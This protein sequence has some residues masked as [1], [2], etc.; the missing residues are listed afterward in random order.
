MVGAG[1]FN[2]AIFHP[3]WFVDKGLISEDEVIEDQI[4][5][6]DDSLLVTSAISAFTADW[7]SVRVTETKAVFSTVEQGR[8]P[9]LKDLARGVLDLLPET[10]VNAIGINADAHFRIESEDAWHAIGDQFLPKD[11]WEPI[12]EDGTWVKRAGDQAVGLRS[13]T[14]E[15][16]RED[17]D[18]YVSLEVAPSQRIQW[19]VFVGANAHFQLSKDDHRG[20]GFEAARIIDEQWD[21]ARQVEQQAIDKLAS[22]S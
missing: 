17:G 21:G 4:P 2:P 19:G 6:E 13:L 15:V 5:G 3:R 11:V 18:G 10:P 9:D 1:A 22:L 7:L 16:W 20:N 8:E 12:F 14:V